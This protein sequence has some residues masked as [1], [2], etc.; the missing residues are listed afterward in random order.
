[1]IALAVIFFMMTYVGAIIYRIF[2]SHEDGNATSTKFLKK[3]VRVLFSLIGTMFVHRAHE[4]GLFTGVFLIG[5]LMVGLLIG[6]IFST[7]FMEFLMHFI[8]NLK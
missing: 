3:L 1:M 2:G 8:L 7:Y 5:A 6:H 4:R